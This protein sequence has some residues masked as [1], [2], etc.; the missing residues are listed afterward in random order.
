MAKV[1]KKIRSAPRR[2][3]AVRL[4]EEKHV[5]RETTEWADVPKDEMP[6]SNILDTLRHYGYFYDK[7]HYV[8]WTTVWMKANRPEDLKYYKAGRR[9]A[10]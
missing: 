6:F 3:N 7:K 10:H 5:G 2:S 1:A 9:L 4:Q 8:E